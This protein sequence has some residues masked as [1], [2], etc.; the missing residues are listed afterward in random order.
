ML[1]HSSALPVRDTVSPGRPSV[2][3]GIQLSPD[4]PRSG[5]EWCSGYHYS[6]SIISSFS[7]SHLSGTG[8]GDLQDI[9]LLPVTTRPQVGEKAIDFITKGYAKFSHANETAEPGYYSV[10]FDNGI[11]TELT[12][13][14]RCGMHSYQYPTNSV[15]GLTLDLTTAR[16]WDR[17][18]MTSI[19]KINNRTIQGYRKSTGWAKEHNVYFFMEF[20]Q[21]VDVWAGNDTLKLLKNGQKLVSNQGYAFIDFGTTTN[22]VLVKVSLSSANCEGA[23]ANLDKELSHWS[24]DQ[25]ETGGETTMETHSI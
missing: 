17:T 10:T 5:W 4:N 3:P 23:A 14:S 8:I 7:H 20:S 25:S 21:D 13:T 12:V 15:Y 19:K 6:D 18:V 24:F 9:R 16:N 1:I 2:W 11:K 22:K